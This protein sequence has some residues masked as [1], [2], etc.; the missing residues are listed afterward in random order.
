MGWAKR[1]LCWSGIHGPCDI[2]EK[3]AI[4]SLYRREECSWCGDISYY[5]FGMRGVDRLNFV[6]PPWKERDIDED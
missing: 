2:E 5:I 3:W 6:P 1:I 4:L